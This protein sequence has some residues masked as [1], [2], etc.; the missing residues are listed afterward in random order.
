[1]KRFHVSRVPV[2]RRLRAFTL[3]ELL[4]VIAIIAI[5]IALLLPAVQQAREAARRTQC[6]NNLR[7]IGLAINN[8]IDTNKLFPMNYDGTL[9]ERNATSTG[10]NSGLGNTRSAVSWITSAL[11]YFDQAPLYKT[12]QGT[13]LF[14]TPANSGRP[15]SNIG[16]DH[17]VVKQAAQTAIPSLLCPSNPQVTLARGG[18]CYFGTGW[19]DGGGGGGTQYQGA[20]TDYVGNLGFVQTGW[21]D[22]PWGMGGFGAQWSSPD[23]VNTYEDNWDN[24]QRVKGAFW[25]RGSAKLAQL[26]DGTATTIVVFENH[27]WAFDPKFPAEQN[28][29]A[30]WIAPVAAMQSL[31]K[32]INTGNNSG[33]GGRPPTWGGD[34]RCTGWTSTHSGGAHALMG[35]GTVRFVNATISIGTGP[36]GGLPPVPGGTNQAGVLKSLATASGGDTVSDF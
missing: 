7:Q 12:I 1:M 26:S 18:L 36:D 10:I 15:G 29:D 8:Y 25:F 35:D 28:L 20:R 30:L 4:V 14:T 31:N 2:L 19:A 16:Y 13:G 22:C 3:I 6:K 9:N 33:V 27:H 5:L 24:Y 34:P 21:K 23:W 11:P 17:P 32:K